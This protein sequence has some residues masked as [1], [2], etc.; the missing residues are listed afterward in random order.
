M[1]S[2]NVENESNTKPHCALYGSHLVCSLKDQLEQISAPFW[3]DLEANS[4]MHVFGNLIACG[5]TDIP[6][7]LPTSGDKEIFLC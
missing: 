2:T 3:Q 4:L 1:L 7:K 5:F 6:G